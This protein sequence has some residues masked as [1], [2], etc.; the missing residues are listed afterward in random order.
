MADLVVEIHVPLTPTPG[1]GPSDYA[2]PWIDDVEAYLGDLDGS[3]GEVY[4]DGEELGDE[5][6]FFVGG[7]PEADLVQ[8]ARR[9]SELDGVP[10]GVYAVVND[11]EGAMGEGRRIDLQ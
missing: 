5:Y 6:V 8:V 3:Q 9:V 11:S 2:F 10:K 1:R 4:D 7:A